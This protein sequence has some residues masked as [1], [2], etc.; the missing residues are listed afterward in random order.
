MKHIRAI[1]F[2]LAITLPGYI[3]GQYG[4]NENQGIDSKELKPIEYRSNLT[5]GGWMEYMASTLRYPMKSKNNNSIGFSISGI[6][7]T[8]SG[9]IESISIINSID[10]WIDKEVIDLL[11][12]TKNYWLENDTI[13]EN[14]TFYFQIAFVITGR[15][16]APKVDSPVKNKYF[17]EPVIVTA[18]MLTSGEL[19]LSRDTLA[20]RDSKRIK[21]GDYEQSLFYVDELIK[22]DPFNKDLYQL[23]IFISTKAG[24]KDL[25]NSDIQKIN[26][27]IPGVSLE[28]L[29]SE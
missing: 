10:Q 20:A 25:I 16:T 29:I 24:R 28:K 22:R 13:I 15:G 4:V 23:R 19:P 6:T 21:A 26:N 12:E 14:Q 11:E 5:E 1:I 17:F 9:E 8:P 3:I 7:I 2:L 18:Q 27:F